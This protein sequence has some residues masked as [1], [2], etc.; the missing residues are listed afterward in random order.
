MGWAGMAWLGCVGLECCARCAAASPWRHRNAKLRLN[1]GPW[2][3]PPLAG[4]EQGG[5]STQFSAIPLNLAGEGDTVDY[6]VTGSWS[7][8]A[9][10]GAW[11]ARARPAGA[12]GR[13][14]QQRAPG[15]AC[16]LLAVAGEEH[17]P[18]PTGVPPP[19][20]QH[21]RMEGGGQHPASGAPLSFAV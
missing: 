7:K 9:A 10:G 2:L 8:K 1:P 20:Q 21:W 12:G 6:L 11:P 17:V 4:C 18:L 16:L 13:G 3:P 19:A 5:A 15:L 14:P